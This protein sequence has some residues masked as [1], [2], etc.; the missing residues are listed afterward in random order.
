MIN[1]FKVEVFHNRP[2]YRRG[3]LEEETVVVDCKLFKTRTSAKDY[4]EKQLT[5]KQNVSRSYHRGNTPSTCS[6][7]TNKTW[8][9]E[10][11]GEPCNEYFVYKLIKS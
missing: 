2:C 5:G 6:Y 3:D 8:T 10:N 11:T 7:Y 4:I 9:N 1:M